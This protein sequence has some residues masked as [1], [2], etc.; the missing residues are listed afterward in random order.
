VQGS[1]LLVIVLVAYVYARTVSGS[2]EAARA[3]AFSVLVVSNLALIQANRRWARQASERPRWNAAFGWIAVITSG[4]LATIL[5]IP[6][7]GGL[8]AFVAPMPNL[9][10]VGAGLCL[11][12]FGWFEAVKWLDAHSTRQHA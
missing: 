1:G 3:L 11:L 7:V 6:A 9:L 5:A 10:A 12:A 8:F 2:D 4:L